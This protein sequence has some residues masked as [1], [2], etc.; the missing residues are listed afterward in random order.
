MAKE[1]GIRE[2]ERKNACG[3][4]GG[5]MCKL[6]PRGAQRA[7]SKR[8]RQRRSQR[9]GKKG[10]GVKDGAKDGERG[11]VC[12]LKYYSQMKYRVGPGGTARVYF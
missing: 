1:I 8:E 5:M 10:S 9:V 7:K 2:N 6:V 12:T 3:S 11:D 4:G